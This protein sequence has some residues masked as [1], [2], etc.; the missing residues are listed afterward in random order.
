MREGPASQTYDVYGS[1]IWACNENEGHIG[2][3]V[4]SVRVL[5]T[6]WVPRVTPAPHP[7][8]GDTSLP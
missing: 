2:S 5:T 3:R 6:S 8:Q 7:R 4:R 1:R